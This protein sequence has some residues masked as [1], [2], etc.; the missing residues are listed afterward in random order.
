MC[1][2]SELAPIFNH[3]QREIIMMKHLM[4]DFVAFDSSPPH[5]IFYVN[6]I[7]ADKVNAKAVCEM[8]VRFCFSLES[9]H[10]IVWH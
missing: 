5:F 8:I 2:F 7:I 6:F 9:M 10:R 3:C 1:A 4:D